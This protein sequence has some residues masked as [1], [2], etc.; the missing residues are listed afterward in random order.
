MCNESTAF[1]FAECINILQPLEVR[2]A[3]ISR[4][5]GSISHL[6]TRKIKR[7]AW[8]A[9]VGSVLKHV[10]GTMDEDDAIQYGNAIQALGKD[11]NAL[12]EYM[13]DNILLT[14][15]AITTFNQTITQLIENE[16]SLNSAVVS[17]TE[18]FKNLTFVS[19]TLTIKT[20]IMEIV[21]ILENSLLTLSFKLEDISNGLMF[22][23]NN[24]LYPAI[25]S[26]QE[27]YNDLVIN[28]RHLPNSKELPLT[29][30]LSNIHKLLKI[31]SISTYYFDNKII[32]IVKIPLV[33]P[34]E[35]GL[36]V[37]HSLPLPTL[38]QNNTY[39]TI[40]PS[41]TYVGL[42]RDKNQYCQL[43]NLD[44]C[45]SLKA[46]YICDKV[47]ILSSV[48]HPICETEIVSKTITY[49]PNQC[50]IKLFKGNL[51][52]WQE[53]YNNEWIFVISNVTKF[54]LDCQNNNV[55][56][57]NI[58]G[59]GVLRVPLGCTGFCNG[60]Q[61]FTKQNI[62][63]NVTH[64]N[65]DYDIINS[66]FSIPKYSDHILP[67]VNIKHFNIKRVLDNDQGFATLNK[68]LNKFITKPREIEVNHFHVPIIVYCMLFIIIFY[69]GYKI[70]LCRN[71]C[72]SPSTETS[73]I[74][75]PASHP[76]M[77][78]SSPTTLDTPRIR[79]QT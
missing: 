16:K 19:A 65:L 7:S 9:G 37:Y 54:T 57:T 34:L 20:R 6:L 44:N 36:R 23:K 8:F 27:L 12:A 18:N 14:T 76:E 79:I 39:S 51:E 43:D 56:E 10:F 41:T 30:D 64:I 48:T 60:F 13:K 77:E 58:I 47:N 25:C 61:L 63:I 38:H 74:F 2:L 24:V 73:V 66:N 62:K 22:S 5:F 4:D 49:I 50:P 31:S 67:E 26:P 11:Q 55:Y 53:L 78:L 33:H 1:E 40:I 75:H 35:F 68:E 15:S 32:F 29:L 28:Y 42:S 52:I 46:N 17:L 21:T 71:R 45:K 59:T 69:L 72:F 3:D 70:Y